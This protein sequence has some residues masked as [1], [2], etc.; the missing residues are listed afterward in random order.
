MILLFF[1]TV[2]WRWISLVFVIFVYAFVVYLIIKTL[3]QNRNPIST[4]SWVMVLIMIPFL[5]IVLYLL[6]GQK[7]ARRW[8]FRKLHFKELQQMNQ[9]VN[10]QLNNYRKKIDHIYF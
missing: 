4:L 5:G 9:I 2:A 7:L 1:D 6:F 8:I 10:S 3:L